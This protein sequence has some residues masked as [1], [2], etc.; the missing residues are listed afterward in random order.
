MY[1]RPEH[2]SL[3]IESEIGYSAYIYKKRHTHNHGADSCADIIVCALVIEN[4][5]ITCVQGMV[6]LD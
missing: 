5:R 1:N 3:Q 2:V 6:F 4:N